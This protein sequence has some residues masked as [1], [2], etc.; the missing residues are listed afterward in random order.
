MVESAFKTMYLVS[1]S[2]IDNNVKRNFK[3]SLQNKDICDGGMSV[4][5]RPI[6]KRRIRN[7]PKVGKS[8]QS[9]DRDDD[10]FNDDEDGKYEDENDGTS[11]LKHQY[12]KPA[13]QIPPNYGFSLRDANTKQRGPL[14]YD[15][16]KQDFSTY[17]EESSNDDGQDGRH[18]EQTKYDQIE[19]EP[20]RIKAK[21][22]KKRIEK[23]IK[24]LKRQRSES[25]SDDKNNEELRD[26]TTHM[27][28]RQLVNYNQ[29]QQDSSTN[30]DMADSRNNGHMDER[31]YDKKYITYDKDQNSDSNKN[32]TMD[33]AEENP[34]GENSDKSEDDIDQ[35]REGIKYRKKK[36]GNKM[37][38][39]KK[40]KMI[41]YAKHLS[42]NHRGKDKNFDRK[43]SM[44]IDPTEFGKEDI[45]SNETTKHKFDNN[46]DN[47]SNLEDINL[48]RRKIEDDINKLKDDQW[49]GRIKSRL[50]DKR[51]QF[52]RKQD[53]VGYR[54]NPDDMSKSLIKPSDFTYLNKNESADFLDKW[55]P[56]KEL[57]SKPFKNKRFKPYH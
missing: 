50:N 47:Q 2:N 14:N 12:Y 10:Q 53:T 45:Q 41:G 11:K 48:K 15:K 46:V 52:K 9:L 42:K 24:Q 30:L 40:R 20:R 17:S 44:P 29:P 38:M 23:R 27:E 7:K 28:K 18:H 6:K 13:K 5:V 8:V 36:K 22:R 34:T 55:K 37:R 35:F 39:F 49:M 25:D 57:R 4:S 31:N 43:S 54:I 21:Y 16:P 56:L 26:N 51:V 1:E 32:T 3:L 33:E 19:L